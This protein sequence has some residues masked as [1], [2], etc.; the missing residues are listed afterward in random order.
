MK[1]NSRRSR[2]MECLELACVYI[3]RERFT[4][5]FMSETAPK[6]VIRQAQMVP[7]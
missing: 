2:S 4:K 1:I 7:K 6:T 5:P 3:E